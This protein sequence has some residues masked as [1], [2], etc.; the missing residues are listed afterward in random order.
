MDCFWNMWPIFHTT[1]PNKSSDIFILFKCCVKTKTRKTNP[2]HL[3]YI[4][5]CIIHVWMYVYWKREGQSILWPKRSRWKLFDCEIITFLWWVY[6]KGTWKILC[7]YYITFACIYIL[8]EFIDKT[9]ADFIIFNVIM[10]NVPF[11][12]E[13]PIYSYNIIV[14]NY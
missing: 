14:L 8:C 4:Y 6:L 12:T 2:I 13:S 7:T 1:F 11:D 9:S 3:F 5:I 10:I